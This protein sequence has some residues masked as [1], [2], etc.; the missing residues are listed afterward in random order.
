[1]HYQEIPYVAV[2]EIDG[3]RHILKAMGSRHE[4]TVRRH[5]EQISPT[6]KLISLV[7]ADLND[8]IAHIERVKK[9]HEDA[10]PDQEPLTAEKLNASVANA[11]AELNAANPLP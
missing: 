3:E 1:M 5:I 10:Y 9:E 11:A 7:K 4:A 2:V 8:P 6:L